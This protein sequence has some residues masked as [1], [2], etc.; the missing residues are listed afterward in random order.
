[1]RVAT[2]STRRVVSQSMRT[3]HFRRPALRAGLLALALAVALPAW[4]LHLPSL[5]WPFHHRAATAPRPVAEV[6]VSG[7]AAA[8]IAQVWDRN[9][10]QLDLT[11]ISG[12]G[13]ALL[14]PHAA[15]EWPVRLEFRV[16]PG[17]IGRLEVVGAQRLI[18]TVPAQGSTALLRLDPSVY[19]VDTSEINLHWSVGAGDSAH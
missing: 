2:L 19:R 12:E 14:T 8:S 13:S 15:G 3:D 11:R 7:T 6:S 17:S 18:F 16:R 4:A 1:V 5:H 9:T 10:L